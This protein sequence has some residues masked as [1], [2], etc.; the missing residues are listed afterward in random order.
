VKISLTLTLAFLL[1]IGMLL[2]N[3]VVIMF[4]QQD[5]VR[6]EIVLARS[7]ISQLQ[8]QFPAGAGDEQL[9]S[10][11]FQSRFP[12]D[13]R[14]GI[15]LQYKGRKITVPPNFPLAGPLSAMMAGPHLPEGETVRIDG[16]LWDMFGLFRQALFVVAPLEEQG[17]V[18]G[19]VGLAR[20]LTPFFTCLWQSEKIIF[21]Y[22]LLNVLLLTVV[23]FFRLVKQVVRPIEHLVQLADTY[24]DDEH[25]LFASESGGNEFGQLASS[26]NSMLFRIEHDRKSLQ[27]NVEELDRA[28]RQLRQNQQEMIQAEKLASVGRLAAGLAHEIG[29][30]LGIKQGYLGLL[31][32][33]DIRQEEA[34]EYVRRA[35]NELQRINT[36]VRQL[37]DFARS[38]RGQEEIV[39]VHV[40]L[41]DL[42][43]MLQVQPAV[44]GIRLSFE[45]QAEQDRVLADP[46]QLRQVFLNC[47]MNSVDAIHEKD[48]GGNGSI[49][50]IT[51][52]LDN[53]DEPGGKKRLRVMIVD[54]GI[55]LAD[56]LEDSIFDPF[57][58]S[59][60]PGRGTGLGLSV[61]LSA[62][63]NMGGT[64]RVE[65]STE[66]GMT[67]VIT[68]PL[69]K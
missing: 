30:P 43:K 50:V 9:L 58:S 69:V 38:P 13:R 42:G 49:E 23:G 56:D 36:L 18:V 61:S 17:T 10:R 19:T 37:L 35:G 51:S 12:E 6:H 20:S 33:Q 24:K 65:K 48:T 2:T 66:Q 41:S 67:M 29:N 44:R 39:S 14:G 22:L 5:V 27:K 53:P 54:D 8:E 64:M 15:L 4:W 55:G 28:N 7:V 47:L 46:D 34:A 40:L 60:E 31:A 68:L 16:S 25:L 62:V 52:L 11:L 26:L 59:K 63:E 1:T 3:L 57:V 32:K 21:I 45:L